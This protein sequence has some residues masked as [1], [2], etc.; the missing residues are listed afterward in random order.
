MGLEP[1]FRVALAEADD[2]RRHQARLV[3]EGIG[4]GVTEAHDGDELRALLADGAAFDVIVA[5]LAMPRWSGMEFVSEI[6]ARGNTTPI[7]LLSGNGHVRPS[8][9]RSDGILVVESESTAL[10][11]KQAV[12][13]SV[14]IPP[15]GPVRGTPL[16]T[17]R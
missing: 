9:R 17:Q 1:V 6:R 16:A 5:D 10:A 11:L 2:S 3:L 13:A 7:V 14:R 15:S 4:G 8:V 12:L